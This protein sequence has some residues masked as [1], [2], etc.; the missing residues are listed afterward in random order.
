MPLPTTASHTRENRR[1][2]TRARVV[3]EAEAA[4]ERW[5]LEEDEAEKELKKGA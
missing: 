1:T 5:R 4:I 2:S 3:W